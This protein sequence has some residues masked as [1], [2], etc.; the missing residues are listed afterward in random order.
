M[1]QRN[2]A[3]LDPKFQFRDRRESVILSSSNNSVILQTRVKRDGIKIA[4]TSTK[5][6]TLLSF[7]DESALCLIANANNDT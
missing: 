3:L 5:A 1:E 2:A 6:V 7:N 4:D